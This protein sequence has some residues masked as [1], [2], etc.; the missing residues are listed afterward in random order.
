MYFSHLNQI[1]RVGICY[2]TKNNTRNTQLMPYKTIMGVYRGLMEVALMQH[3]NC[4]QF[5]SFMHTLFLKE[6][7]FTCNFKDN[8]GSLNSQLADQLHPDWGFT[9]A[10]F[11]H[12]PPPKACQSEHPCPHVCPVSSWCWHPHH[13]F[14]PALWWLCKQRQYLTHHKPCCQQEVKLAAALLAP[15]ISSEDLDHRCSTPS[16]YSVSYRLLWALTD[17]LSLSHDLLMRWRLQLP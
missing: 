8:Q 11:G 16:N 4:E 17:N 15:G 6:R 5:I 1:S 2:I 14:V 3:G 13:T 9:L 7:C 10:R 12:K